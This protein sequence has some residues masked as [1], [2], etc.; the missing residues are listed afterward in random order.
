MM[1]RDWIKAAQ[2]AGWVVKS[3]KGH[4]ITLGCACHGCHGARSYLLESL[5]TAPPRCDLPHVNGYARP[6]FDQYSVLVDELRRRRMDIGLDQMDLGEAM[7]VP[8]GYVN[9]M[10][11]FARTASPVMLLLWAQSLGLELTSRPVALPPATI[12]AIQD[13]QSRP[14]DPKHARMK[15]DR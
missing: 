6:A 12:K 11:S 7:G 4:T 10:E 8:D 9:K 15:H 13:R 1:V 14:Y 3:V 2:T 5:D